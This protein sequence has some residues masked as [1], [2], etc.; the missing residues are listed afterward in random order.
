MTS[1]AQ[2]NEP[3]RTCTLLAVKVVRLASAAAA[4]TECQ[5]SLNT[6]HPIHHTTPHHTTGSFHEQSHNAINKIQS[7][8]TSKSLHKT[9]KHCTSH[10]RMRSHALERPF[11]GQE[12]IRR[13]IHTPHSHVLTRT[14]P[15]YSCT[16]TRISLPPH[17]CTLLPLASA[18]VHSPTFNSQLMLVDAG[19]QGGPFHSPSGCPAF[20]STLVH[21]LVPA[22]PSGSG[23]DGEPSG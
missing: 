1:F 7:R 19:L 12:N 11:P 14:Y 10:C 9:N 8:I 20:A 4:K 2:R 23:P 13:T 21:I 16:L 5:G 15:Q 18:H 22:R 3:V 17:T 6:A